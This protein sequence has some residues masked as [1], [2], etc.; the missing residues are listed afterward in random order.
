MFSQQPTQTPAAAPAVAPAAAPTAMPAKAT[1]GNA[2]SMPVDGAHH[3]K[4]MMHSNPANRNFNLPSLNSAEMEIQGAALNNDPK[5]QKNSVIQN[6]IKRH[7]ILASRIWIDTRVRDS[8]NYLAIMASRPPIS[9]FSL[10]TSKAHKLCLTNCICTLLH[11][12]M[13]YNKNSILLTYAE[14]RSKMD[15]SL[16]T[17]AITKIATR[18]HEKSISSL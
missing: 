11:M 18:S 12:K 3:S 9:Y 6:K 1:T 10:T 2:A 14:Y 16:T 13:L 17:E 7:S 5:Q 15:L 4:D 8:R